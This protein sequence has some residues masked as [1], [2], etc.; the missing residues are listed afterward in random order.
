VRAILTILCLA[1]L[2]LFSPRA[3]A[4]TPAPCEADSAF[5]T[6]DFWLGD[7]DV[8]VGDELAG[9]NRIEKILDGC[10]ILEHWTGSGGGQGKSLF[11][12]QKSTGVWKQVWVTQQAMRVGGLKEKQ[13]VA[14]LE[15]GGVRFRG[16]IARGDGTTYLDRTTL[17]PLPDGRVR[18]VIEVS[19]DGG[20]TWRATFD[21]NYVKRESP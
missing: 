20:N 16:E 6:L 17:T 3:G 4:Q 14:R 15:D 19:E 10:A 21:A 11:Y 7:W 9:T 18:Q 1:S 2:L 8:Y 12:Y 5:S 13:L